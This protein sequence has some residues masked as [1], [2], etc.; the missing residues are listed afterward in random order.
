MPLPG[1]LPEADLCVQLVVAGEL[2]QISH[3]GA[4]LADFD[5]MVALADPA[6]KHME[7]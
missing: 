1:S 6:V 5:S 2:R 3:P 4:T 7:L